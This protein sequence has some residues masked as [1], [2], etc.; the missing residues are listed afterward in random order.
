MPRRNKPMPKGLQVYLL[1]K[2][3]G[4]LDSFTIA[5]YVD[6][7]MTFPENL[8]NLETNHLEEILRAHHEMGYKEDGDTELLGWNDWANSQEEFWREM[9]KNAVEPEKD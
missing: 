4:N 8:W 2:H 5:D 9:A 7:Q 3:F 6:S 1:K